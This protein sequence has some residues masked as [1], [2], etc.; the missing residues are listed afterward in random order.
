MNENKSPR[1][2]VVAALDCMKAKRAIDDILS[3]EP[4]CYAIEAVKVPMKYVDDANKQ[5][6][7]ATHPLF[8]KYIYIK[9][10]LDDIARLIAK[11]RSQIIG[12]I[13]GFT[14][15]YAPSVSQEAITRFFFIC[16]AIAEVSGKKKFSFLDISDSQLY[17]QG[18]K[19][20]IIGG[21]LD[22][23]EAVIVNTTEYPSSDSATDSQ[24]AAI[25]IRTRRFKRAT[26]LI[27][28]FDGTAE[29]VDLHDLTVEESSEQKGLETVFTDVELQ[30]DV[31]QSPRK[32]LY[33]LLDNF[34]AVID[35]L[36]QQHADGIEDKDYIRQAY[37]F[38]LQAKQIYIPYHDL[39]VNLK[40]RY[41]VMLMLCHHLVGDTAECTYWLDRCDD[42][43]LTPREYAQKQ[44]S[45]PTA[46]PKTKREKPPRHQQLKNKTILHPQLYYCN[47][48]RTN[49]S[50]S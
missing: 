10:K 9:G 24:S 23:V 21:T 37:S 14:G 3:E 7:A 18:S 38:I 46:K 34:Y 1:W 30:A 13:I 43:L 27:P 41:A 40:S 28:M 32:L 5:R 6:I 49:P 11:Y 20:R 2:Y 17:T 26:L 42:L 47:I 36:L 50:L 45:H 35:T 48:V 22:G 33:A 4:G 19:V 8:S 15:T 12:R 31:T 44:S 16:E 25:T 29:P 39:T